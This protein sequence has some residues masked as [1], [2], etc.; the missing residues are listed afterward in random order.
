MEISG[1][2]RIIGLIGT[3]IVQVKMPGVMNAYCRENGIDVAVIPMDVAPPGVPELMRMIRRWGNLLG[4]IVT[5]PFKQVVAGLCDDLTQRAQRLTTANIVRRDADGRL[6]GDILDG[7]G[8]VEAAR[9]NGRMPE[10]LSAAVIGAGGVASAIADALCESG[11][12]R[13]AIQDVDPVKQDRLVATLRAAFPEVRVS[14]GIGAVDDLDLLVNGTP[15]G[16]NGDPSLPLAP[17]L[18]RTL[19]ASCYAA[20]VVTAPLMTPFLKLA[21]SRG[22]AIQTG[23]EMTRPQLMP[24]ARFL[25]VS[26]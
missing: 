13:L 15:V 26:P 2:T 8:F 3:P 25:G 14:A 10:S 12:A 17:A 4:I 22:C 16:M 20:D 21:E 9:A 7:V 1:T 23:I 19:P 18:L 24:M 5:V 11:V 6:T